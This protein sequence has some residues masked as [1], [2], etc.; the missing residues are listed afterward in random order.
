MTD[1]LV[2]CPACGEK[3]LHIPSE[4]QKAHGVMMTC[5]NCGTMVD[6]VPRVTNRKPTKQ[7]KDKGG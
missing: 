5:R 3:G 6:F 1:I 7:E 2:V 4:S